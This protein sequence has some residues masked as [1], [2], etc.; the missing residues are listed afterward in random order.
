MNDDG[1]HHGISIL[2]NNT[3]LGD[4]KEKRSKV[5]RLKSE[6]IQLKIKH[7][8]PSKGMNLCGS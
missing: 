2:K 8:S 7:N 1:N 6:D 4:L 5:C 3:G